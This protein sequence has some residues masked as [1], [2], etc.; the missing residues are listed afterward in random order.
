MSSNDPTYHHFVVFG[1]VDETT[2]KIT[3]TIDDDIETH[4]PDGS[5]YN[6]DE[7]RHRIDSDEAYEKAN[8]NDALLSQVLKQRLG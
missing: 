2:G 4:F 1:V 8:A 6:D 5:L 3:F 7:D